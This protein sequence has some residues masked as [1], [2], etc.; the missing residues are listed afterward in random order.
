MEN[1]GLRVDDWKMEG[2][3][4]K[5]LGFLELVNYFLLEIP[6]TESMGLCTWRSI[7]SSTGCIPF[8]VGSNPGARLCIGWLRSRGNII[9]WCMV[10]E[11]SEVIRVGAWRR[12]SP[13]A[14]AVR[15]EGGRG[16]CDRAILEFTKGREAVRQWGLIDSKDGFREHSR[17]WE[18]AREWDGEVWWRL[19]GAGTF[20][21]GAGD[22]RCDIPPLSRDGQS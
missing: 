13:L 12:R 15:G 6:W 18:W 16:W 19:A 11:G 2:L 10:D 21:R 8:V 17:K 20:Y 9:R 22:G 3:F 1:F 4:T 7:G 14:I 5:W